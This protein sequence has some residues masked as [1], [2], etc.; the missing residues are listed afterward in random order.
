[1]PPIAGSHKHEHDHVHHQRDEND[2]TAKI[3]Y[4]QH[5]RRRAPGQ[6]LRRGDA[7]LMCRAK[8]LK[9]SA[10]K[11]MCDQCAKRKDRCVYDAVRPASRVEKLEKKLA[12]MD[13][14]DFREAVIRRA[15]A[16]GLGPIDFDNLL[17]QI[18]LSSS[19]S[20]VG[21]DN[22]IPNFAGYNLLGFQQPQ[23]P[24]GHAETPSPN[25]VDQLLNPDSDQLVD[26]NDMPLSAWPWPSSAT[27]S[28]FHLNQVN[29]QPVFPSNQLPTTQIHQ[30][31]LPWQMLGSS[32]N[33]S[34]LNPSDS[35]PVNGLFDT[36][37][38]STA[39]GSAASSRAPSHDST[40]SPTPPNLIN[41]SSSP[42]TGVNGLNIN[43]PLG[44]SPLTPVDA[45][46]PLKPLGLVPN[47]NQ[48]H[49]G[50]LSNDNMGSNWLEALS[51]KTVIP[52]NFGITDTSEVVRSVMQVKKSV[53]SEAKAI[54]A[55]ELSEGARDYLLDLFFGTDTP[56]PLY[57]SEMFSEE[58]FRSRLALPEKQRPH[59]C[60]VFSMCTI[61]A[62]ESYVPS[63]RKLA[64][65]LF[66]I[67]SS[68]LE[69]S[70][71]KQ[72]RLVDA[73]RASKN[74]SKWLFTQGR[75]HEGFQF[76]CKTIALCV[77]CGLHRIPSSIFNPEL[78]A[79]YEGKPKY[80]LDPPTSQ[81]ELAERIHAF[82]SAWGNDK[83]GCITHGWPST[84]RDEEIITPL[85]RSREDYF[86]DILHSE[87]DMTLRDLYDLPYRD[88]PIP[89]KSIF[90]FI[91][92]AE[93]LIYRSMTLLDQ[94][95]ESLAS[96]FR[97][98]GLFGTSQKFTP[99]E[100]YPTAYKEIMETSIWLESHIPEEWTAKF[101]L[102]HTWAEPD[103]PIV[104]LCL[105]T[106]RMHLHPL[107][108]EIDRSVGLG[109]A[110]ECAGL[111]KTLQTYYERVVTSPNPPSSPTQFGAGTDTPPATF[112]GINSQIPDNK[113]SGRHRGG[114]SGPYGMSP[115]Y[116]VVVKLID[117]SRILEKLG[118]V[119]ESKKCMNQVEVIIDGFRKLSQHC[120]IIGAYV[121][122]LEK[123]S[124]E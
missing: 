14:Q 22:G 5:G 89:P 3:G 119:E 99:R 11:P 75:V 17:G 61:A 45:M 6:P 68:K 53:R 34:F 66:K 4:H 33:I 9:C 116:G 18:P 98:M 123:L 65:P 101:I 49:P 84:L 31:N 32:D 15:A 118:Q 115:C 12:E 51:S 69:I 106:A 109:L 71:R 62:T 47:L 102:N 13:E 52:P 72:D 105:K 23:L 88:N 90:C 86:S 1:M 103:I 55:K 26:I 35:P 2:E 42:A 41:H 121:E 56:R 124:E 100:H 40:A 77:A 81:W 97:S 10:Q 87:P 94:P 122:K 19:S 92:A 108:N 37:I 7:C 8:K 28:F 107:D 60:L 73:I 113:S 29:H 43:L 80:L 76:S 25:A 114:I 24:T 50:I 38:P 39:N 46:S 64:E 57:G 120:K 83:G 48:T 96:S 110:F 112:A 79:A 93:T 16:S 95:P 78:Q 91:I 104:A 67:A 21:Q 20:T 85:P 74:L 70:I 30:G 63:I 58:E 117:G 54:R 44:H 111:I 59:P 82:W 36:S 27:N